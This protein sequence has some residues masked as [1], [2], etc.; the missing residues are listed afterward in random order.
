[1]MPDE[2]FD[3][4]SDWCVDHAI[5]FLETDMESSV[6]GRDNNVKRLLD[7]YG[8]DEERG[9]GKQRL[10][11][12]LSQNMWPIMQKK[13]KVAAVEVEEAPKKRAGE[14]ADMI[15]ADLM[16][17]MGDPDGPDA[18]EKAITAA[19]EMREHALTLPDDER[20]EFASKMALQ[21]M[22]LMSDFG[23]DDDEDEDESENSA[24]GTI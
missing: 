23:D 7:D 11:E 24:A 14:A 12:A 17:M 20:R 9:G 10:L 19:R 4:W 22:S 6:G 16:E 18:F 5:E 13:D 2:R 15:D 21:L 8:G 3:A 1:M